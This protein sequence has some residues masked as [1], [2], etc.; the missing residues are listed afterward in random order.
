VAND[1]GEVLM[2]IM[3][4]RVPLTMLSLLLVAGL[5]SA[6]EELVFRDDY[7]SAKKQAESQGKAMVV[8]FE[9]AWCPFCR[10]MERTTF[11]DPEVLKE[12]DKVVLVKVDA[13]TQKVLARRFRVGDNFPLFVFVDRQGEELFRLEGYHP[14]SSFRLALAALADE[15]S[16]L[17]KARRRAAEG[18]GKGSAQV[19]LGD[20]YYE[21]GAKAEAAEAYRQAMEG[22]LEAGPHQRAASRRA[23]YLR[24]KEE[25][26]EAEKLYIMLLERYPDSERA[27]FYRLGLVNTYLGWGRDGRAEEEAK[28]L[29]ADNPGHP[30]TESAA[31]LVAE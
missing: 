10:A 15:E 18:N 2:R 22:D 7:A 16:K 30:A 11:K 25:W 9:T 14:A 17:V 21:V 26:R 23:E 19:E 6:A 27:P 20:A 3:S 24:E 31:K 5:C 12:G 4:V 8:E 1:Q 28:R 29:A 13:D